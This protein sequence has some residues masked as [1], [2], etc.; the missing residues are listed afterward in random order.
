MEKW[1]GRVR[2]V[3]R[4]PLLTMNSTNL[5]PE[6]TLHSLTPPWSV[7]A[8]ISNKLFSTYSH[9]KV[10]QKKTPTRVYSPQTNSFAL[11]MC[12]TDSK[13]SAPKLAPPTAWVD[14][15]LQKWRPFSCSWIYKM[16]LLLHV[17]LVTVVC[18]LMKWKLLVLTWLCLSLQFS[19][20]LLQH[21]L[22]EFAILAIASSTMSKC[23]TN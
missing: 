17:T 20:P 4:E 8:G 19:L 1:V 5:A 16:E 11:S 21:R 23:W 13:R 3:W 6:M 2:G 18:E 14:R 9:V 7:I 15:Y 10:A 12:L 22:M